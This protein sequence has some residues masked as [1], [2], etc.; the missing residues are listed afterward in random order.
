MWERTTHEIINAIYTDR[1]S[2]SNCRCILIA[3]LTESILQLMTEPIFTLQLSLILFSNVNLLSNHL[4][5]FKIWVLV[6]ICLHSIHVPVLIKVESI[7]SK[8]SKITRLL[9]RCKFQ[10][11]S[12][13]ENEMY[14]TKKNSKFNSPNNRRRKKRKYSINTNTLN[15]S[16]WFFL[17]NVTNMYL[18]YKQSK[19]KLTGDNNVPRLV[20]SLQWSV[21]QIRESKQSSTQK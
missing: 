13:C 8:I 21:T 5:C 3:S 1:Y 10:N 18:F 6:T 12:C 4:R 19:N 9:F 7:L 11:I 17:Y 16:S 15:L 14:I 2:T 20:C